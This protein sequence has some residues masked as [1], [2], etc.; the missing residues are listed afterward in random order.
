M[1][2]MHPRSLGLILFFFFIANPFAF[3]HTGHSEKTETGQAL[4]AAEETPVDSIYSADAGETEGST[5]ALDASLDSPLSPSNLFGDD[6]LLS[7]AMKPAGQMDHGEAGHGG[8]QQERQGHAQEPHVEIA[9]HKWVSTS[10]KGYGVAVGI[11]LLSG[12]VFGILSFRRPNELN[13]QK[14]PLGG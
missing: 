8:K 5:E 2:I 6:D 12:L 4:D 1:R 13:R 9:T 7:P 10:K 11:T 14:R 3:A